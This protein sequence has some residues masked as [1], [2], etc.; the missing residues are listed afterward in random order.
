MWYPSRL[1]TH[2]KEHF[3]KSGHDCHKD[4][5]DKTRQQIDVYE[6]EDKKV[7]K[8][9]LIASINLSVL[10]LPLPGLKTLITVVF[11]IGYVRNALLHNRLI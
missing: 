11:D 4:N 5:E 10:D 2:R 6:G 7:T 9:S 8:N 3:L 1:V